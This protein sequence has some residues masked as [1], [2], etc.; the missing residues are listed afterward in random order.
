MLNLPI[1]NND[2]IACFYCWQLLAMGKFY[3]LLMSKINILRIWD[4]KYVFTYS[5]RFAKFGRQKTNFLWEKRGKSGYPTLVRQ[6]I[7][8]Y[9]GCTLPPGSTYKCRN[10]IELRKHLKLWDYENHEI[11]IYAHS[12]LPCQY[13]TKKSKKY[14][15]KLPLGLCAFGKRELYYESPC[16]SWSAPFC[17]G[18]EAAG[19]LFFL[20]FSQRVLFFILKYLYYYFPSHSL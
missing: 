19:Y 18:A 6:T 12:S 10:I 14:L 2:D 16:T 3:H 15:I 17:S 20:Y 13:H 9:S 8:G 5:K 7:G 1:A 4:K 11:R